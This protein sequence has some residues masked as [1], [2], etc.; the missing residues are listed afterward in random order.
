MSLLR[1]SYALSVCFLAI[2]NVVSF[3]VLLLLNKTFLSVSS[4]H[5]LLLPSLFVFVVSYVIN[6]TSDFDIIEFF[7]IYTIKY[8]VFNCFLTFFTLSNFCKSQ[9]FT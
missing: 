7:F 5:C 4:F 1:Q 6:F 9:I 2:S 3:I 8:D